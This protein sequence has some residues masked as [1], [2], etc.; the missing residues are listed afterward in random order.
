MKNKRN[1]R[2]FRHGRVRKRTRGRRQLHRLSV[3]RSNKYLYAQIID[4]TSARTIVSASDISEKSRE[5]KNKIERAQKIGELIAKA[6]LAKKI[7]LVVFDRGGYK[8]HG[9]VKALAEGARVG[10]LQF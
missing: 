2:I 1:Q 4:D 5:V 7:K 8:Y 10:G 3:F 6:A 9:R